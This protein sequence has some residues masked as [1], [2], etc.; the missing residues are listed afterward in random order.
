MIKKNRWRRGLAA[1]AA[2]ALVVSGCSSGQNRAETEQTGTEQTIQQTTQQNAGAETTAAN[3]MAQNQRT[4]N[5][6]D[7]EISF[8]EED[9]YRE[10]EDADP[11][12]IHLDDVAVTI[13]G[14]GAESDGKTIQIT[15]GGTYVLD[16]SWSDGSVQVDAEGTGTVRLV[17][18]GVD[19]HSET[20][21]PVYVLGADKT[22]ISLEPGTVNTLSDSV[23]LVYTDTEK[24][25]PNAVLFSKDDLT[26][27]GTGKLVI[28]ASFDH[29]INGKDDLILMSGEYEITSAGSAFKGKELLV[30]NDGTYQISAGNDGFHSDA[31]LGIVGGTINI[32]E[33]E[34]GIEGATILIQGGDIRLKAF[35]DG[36]NASTDDAMTPAIYITGG[37]LVVDASGDGI[38]SN[39][40]LYMSGGDVTVYGPVNDGNGAIDYDRDFEISGGTLVAFGSGKMTQAVS[41]GSTQNAIMMSYKEK[42]AAGTEI[43]LKTEAGEELYRG[44]G[45]KEFS[46]LVLSIPELTLGETYQL[47]TGETQVAF[48]LE[49]AMTYLSPEGV[50]EAGMGQ[51]GQRGGMPGGG[52]QRGERME[53]PSGERAP[54]GGEGQVPEDMPDKGGERPERPGGE[55]GEKTRLA[56]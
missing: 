42:Q 3:Q 9:Y 54:E 25:E 41:S 53:R 26:I 44:T 8:Q 45:E 28:Q 37:S 32:A 35:D 31:N 55:A 19:I 27:N 4:L 23:G 13:E 22:V 46:S 43:V 18:N 38:D 33:S 6:G 51:P 17:F 52:G 12:Y 21:A 16:G 40:Y 30:V 15:R 7:R 2:A 24:E 20:T 48:T 11:V 56:S 5:I 1:A 50:T 29:G 36:I 14:T 39:G 49:N 47:E 10:W 34:E